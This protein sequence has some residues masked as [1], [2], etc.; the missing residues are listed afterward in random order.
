MTLHLTPKIEEAL[1]EEARRK[2]TTPERLALKMLEEELVQERVRTSAKD[3]RDLAAHGIRRIIG[4][5]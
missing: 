5:D 3:C 4:F 2:G 1:K